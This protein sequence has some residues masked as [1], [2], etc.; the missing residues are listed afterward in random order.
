MLKAGLPA[1]FDPDADRTALDEAFSAIVQG[2][3]ANQLHT[4]LLTQ[5]S[6]SWTGSLAEYITSARDAALADPLSPRDRVDGFICTP[7]M[8]HHQL[9]LRCYN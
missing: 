7:D 6:R 4:A 3:N 8:L 2:C 9:F 5:L 1:G